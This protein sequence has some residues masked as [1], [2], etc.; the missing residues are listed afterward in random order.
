MTARIA[1]NTL[2][3]S[4]L[5]LAGAVPARAEVSRTY[6]IRHLDPGDAAMALQA[7]IPGLR[8][9]CHITPD[10]A[11][12]TKTAGMK[13]VVIAECSSDA[14]FPKI[15][16][17]LAAIDVTPP[18]QRF[19]VLVL[20]AMRNDGPTPDLPPSEAKALADF[21]KVMTYRSFRIEAETVLQ[22]NDVVEAQLGSSYRLGM[23]LSPSG[24]GD[25]IDVR[26]FQLHAASPRST[27]TG[28]QTT[29]TYIETSFSIKKGETIVV[30]TSVTDQQAR[31][32]L[33]TALP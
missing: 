29:P 1:R 19:H 27:P 13:G 26:R 20:E 4:G 30:G 12:D 25:V 3:L 21:R 2:V 5:L 11:H 23:Q 6:G 16:A 8:K 33:V 32:V 10:M 24:V 14:M 18:T 28:A 15:E 7:R 22:S 31:V 9:D 17:A